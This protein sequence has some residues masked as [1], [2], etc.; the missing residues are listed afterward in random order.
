MR[1]CPF[2]TCPQMLVKGKA[3]KIEKNVVFKM[4]KFPNDMV[5]Q[6]SSPY[7][8]F[9]IIYLVNETLLF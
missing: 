5:A 2:E 9:A 7:L 4:L 3:E 8:V 1:Y 6:L